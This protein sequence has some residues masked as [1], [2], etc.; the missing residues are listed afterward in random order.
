MSATL[1]WQLAPP[2]LYTWANWYMTQ[3]DMFLHSPEAHCCGANVQSV[4]HLLFK[5]KT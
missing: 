3:W 4:K 2:T 5:E 1:G